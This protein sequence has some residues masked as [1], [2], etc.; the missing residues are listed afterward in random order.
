MGTIRTL[1]RRDEH[2]AALRLG[3]DL[4][5]TVIDTAEH[6]GYGSAEEIVGQAIAGRRDEVFLVSKV[7]PPDTHI[8]EL[9]RSIKSSV[10]A[11]VR[12]LV[13]QSILS[14]ASSMLRRSSSLLPTSNTAGRTRQTTI[15]ACERSLRRL[16]TDRLDLYLLHWRGTTPLEEVLAA[17]LDLVRMGKIRYFGVSNFG[18]Q[19]LEEWRALSGADATATNQVLY[20][21]NQRGIEQD[22]LPWCRRHGLPIMAYSPL[23][24]GRSLANPTLRQIGARLGA[25]PSQVALAWLVRQGGIVA[26]PEATRLE[27]LRENRAAL[28]VELSPADLATLERAFP[29]KK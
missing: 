6:Y 22:M 10:P 17:F 20:N 13:P 26:I 1:G 25:S 28:S 3:L 11:V 27:H 4:G 9:R 23:D 15:A 19:D 24:K 29:C 18:V 16:R 14:A 12:H 21:L 5:M 2:V 8:V 7:Y